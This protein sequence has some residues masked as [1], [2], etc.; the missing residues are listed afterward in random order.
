MHEF[1]ITPYVMGVLMALWT[2]P[3]I[4]S[5]LIGKL[6]DSLGPIKIGVVCLTMMSMASLATAYSGN[7]YALSA[8]RLLF[9]VFMPLVWPICAKIVSLYV[10]KEMYSLATSVYNTGSMIGLTLTFIIPGLL[11]ENW[12]LVLTTTALIGFSYTVTY[13]YFFRDKWNLSTY[14]T[15][16]A[17][18]SLKER[19]I[20]YRLLIIMTVSFFLALY[21]WGLMV[22]WTSTF[23]VREL[24]LRYEDL[25]PHMILIATL[26]FFVEIS[27]GV[28]SD[29]IGGLKGKKITLITGLLVTGALLAFITVINDIAL[30]STLLF[31]TFIVYRVSAPSFWSIVNEVIPPVLIGRFS[32]IYTLAGPAVGLIT[33]ALNGYIIEVTGSLEIG[34]LIA[35]MI[36][37]L[38]VLMYS[39]V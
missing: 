24:N 5:P 27:S 28:I 39:K 35:S 3:T 19:S 17:D 25:I 15:D 2:A 36:T 1:N 21:P 29:K 30:K 9:A 32:G 13:V 37:L 23:L 34:F 18:N 7:I 8:T 11:A 38:S 10:P 26:S 20:P 33:S 4:L 16:S 22:S 6:V 31:T 12:R 14:K